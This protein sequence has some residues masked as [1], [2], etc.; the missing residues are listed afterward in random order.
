MF[1]LQDYEIFLLLC[2]YRALYICALQT[3]N[4]NR[5]GICFFYNLL[6]H[7]LNLKLY[8]KASHQSSFS[9][10]QW[11]VILFF[12]PFSTIFMFKQ[13]NL[14][15][16]LIICVTFIYHKRTPSRKEQ[17]VWIWVIYIAFSFGLNYSLYFEVLRLHI[18]WHVMQKKSLAFQKFTDLFRSLTVIAIPPFPPQEHTASC[19]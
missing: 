2:C 6:Q 14:I 7:L 10:L 16:K 18:Q 19:F 9:C 15:C 4:T 3:V 17:I 12:L 11:T 5:V 8:M 13:E 1:L